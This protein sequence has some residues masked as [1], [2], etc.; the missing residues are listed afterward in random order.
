MQIT[1]P[2]RLGPRA[3]EPFAAEG[4][5]ADD[6][7]D[8]RAVDI[9]VADA[10]PRENMPH[11]LVDPAVNAERERVAGRGDLVEH[12]IEPVRAPANHMQDRAEHLAIE[13]AGGV[14]LEGSRRE[15]RAVLDAGRQL[16]C[17][18]QPALG[19]AVR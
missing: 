13:P 1:R 14:D 11:G 17:V 7:A 8:H 2:A 6:G 9:A 16:A 12:G 10:E 18:E 5:G 4:L 15:E 19:G 3:A